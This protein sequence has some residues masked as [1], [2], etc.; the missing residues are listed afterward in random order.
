[1]KWRHR[2]IPLNLGFLRRY[3]GSQFLLGRRAADKSDSLNSPSVQF[4][5]SFGRLVD[6]AFGRNHRDFLLMPGLSGWLLMTK[7]GAK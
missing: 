6:D 3:V 4:L 2:T 5:A 7:S 1:M